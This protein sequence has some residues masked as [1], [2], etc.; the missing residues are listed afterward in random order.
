[1]KKILCLVLALCSLGLCS[2]G[3]IISNVV[4]DELLPDGF[5][6]EK[7]FPEVTEVPQYE[8]IIDGVAYADGSSLF[9]GT[10]WEPG[11][12]VTKEIETK[13]NSLIIVNNTINFRC[14]ED[15]CKLGDIIKVV[16]IDKNMKPTSREEAVALFADGNGE[17][18]NAFSLRYKIDP[19]T[20]KAT[21]LVFYFP[22][23]AADE[24]TQAEIMNCQFSAVLTVSQFEAEDDA[25]GDMYDPT[26]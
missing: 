13:N 20:S 4:P 2:C 1:M 24:I 15:N 12:V 8:F 23:E 5:I 14:T 10:I 16:E 19:A 25:F 22:T 6:P 7:N 21:T 11:M 18:L 26:V 3:L 17:S 9:H